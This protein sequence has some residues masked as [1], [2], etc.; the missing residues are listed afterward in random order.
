MPGWHDG[1]MAMRTDCKH[2]QSRTITSGEVIHTCDLDA[3]PDA[4]WSCPEDCILF[5]K[6][7]LSRVGWVMGSLGESSKPAFDEELSDDA[8]SALAEAEAIINEIAPDAVADF[9]RSKKRRRKR[10]RKG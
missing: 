4:P 9:E 7:E 3:A 5:E 6:R 1:A 2:Y 8:E 10:R